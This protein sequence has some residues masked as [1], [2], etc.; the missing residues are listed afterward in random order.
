MKRLMLVMLASAG[1]SGRGC[2]PS[3]AAVDG[4]VLRVPRATGDIVIDGKFEEPQW[5]KPARTQPFTDASGKASARPY[6]DARLLWDANGLLLTMYAADQNVVQRVTRHDEP[7]DAEDAFILLLRT[8]EPART[9]VI[10]VGANG[11]V[12]DAVE[13][14]GEVRDASWESGA[15]VA[16]DLDGTL[17]KEDDDD[18]E[19]IVET[20]IPW[21]ALGIKPRA[22]TELGIDIRRCDTP[23]ASP[24]TCGSYAGVISLSDDP[25]R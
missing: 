20:S 4:G 7:M 17:N 18:E 19:W 24:R 16:L 25:P 12:Y 6:S 14:P 2:S 13:G 3:T 9:L 5:L 11:N 1:C 22:G 23:R 21:T 10:E 15:T 8:R